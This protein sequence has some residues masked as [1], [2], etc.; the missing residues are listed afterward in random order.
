[1]SSFQETGGAQAKSVCNG[2]PLIVYQG[3][4]SLDLEAMFF[5]ALLCWW[6]RAVFVSCV[7]GFSIKDGF[8]YRCKQCV[9]EYTLITQKAAYSLGSL[10]SW[11]MAMWCFGYQASEPERVLG[12]WLPPTCKAKACPWISPYSKPRAQEHDLEQCPAVAA[13]G[14]E[15]TL[16]GL[17]CP[18]RGVLGSDSKPAEHTLELQSRVSPLYQSFFQMAQ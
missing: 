18:S 8:Q 7:F 9:Q 11:T 12:K 17:C 10:A 1:V 2:S 4:L 5:A 6:K 16:S 15:K 3:S 13:G 14:G